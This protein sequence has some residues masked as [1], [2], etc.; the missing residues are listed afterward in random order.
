[1]AT[2]KWANFWQSR[3]FAPCRPKQSRRFGRRAQKD[4]PGFTV[5]F[6]FLFERFAWQSFPQIVFKSFPQFDLKLFS[7]IVC[8][9]YTWQFRVIWAALVMRIA[10][11]YNVLWCTKIVTAGKYQEKWRTQIK[12]DMRS[13]PKYEIP[14]WTN[15][16]K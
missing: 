16:P 5:K 4:N 2:A 7:Q 14:G 12:R 10:T 11:G 8:D 6:Y 1:M 13:W 3:K 15:I 9:S